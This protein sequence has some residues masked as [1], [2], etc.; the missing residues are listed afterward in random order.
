MYEVHA[1]RG[2]ATVDGANSHGYE[3]GS[4]HAVIVF[5]R[6]EPGSEL[7]FALA[8]R[9]AHDNGLLD[10][11]FD[12]GGRLRPEAIKAMPPEFADAYQAALA[13]GYGV[14]IYSEPVTGGA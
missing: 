6:Q 5:S 1:F 3:A 2:E 12:D 9:R 4:R 8:A 7:D 13:Q 11:S 10:V 14:V